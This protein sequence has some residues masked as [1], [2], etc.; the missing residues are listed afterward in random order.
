[1]APEK[2]GGIRGVWS[3]A[4]RRRYPLLLGLVFVLAVL[5][6][7][8]YARWTHIYSYDSYYYMNL[9]RGL[10][11]GFSYSLRGM[12]HGKF[13]PLYPLLTGMFSLPFRN[14]ELAGKAVN[15]AFSSLAVFPIYGMG[16][17]LLDGKAGLFAALFLACEPI[18]VTWSTIPMSEGLFVFLLCT[19]FYLFLR[20]WKARY[21]GGGLLLYGAAFVAGL[22]ALTRWEG[23]LAM[24]IFFALALYGAA[25]KRM[26]YRPVLFMALFFILAYSPWLLR[27]IAVR[28]NP[29]PL[30]YLTEISAHRETIAPL[31]LWGRFK[32]YLIFSESIALYGTTHT[33]NFGL[34]LLGYAGMALTLLRRNLR[35]YFLPLFLWWS[36]LG[37]LH[38]FFFY[39]SSRYIVGAAA[40]LCLYAG[41]AFSSL[42]AFLVPSFPRR[43]LRAITVALMVLLLCAVCAGSIPIIRD[44]FW[45]DILRMEDD[46]GG[47]ALRELMFWARDNLPQDAVLA[48]HAGQMPAFYLGREVLYIGTWSNF[49]PA[50][51]DQ[52]NPWPDV[53]EE[54]VDY[55]ILYASAPVLEEGLL[56]S[57]MPAELASYMEIEKVAVMEPVLDVDDV[58]YA[59]LVSLH[60]PAEP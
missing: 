6:R 27:N 34:L 51:V 12:P 36:L 18:S 32:K 57:G 28:G 50:D 39:F 14:Y 9:A 8:R 47:I 20:W 38:F 44:H 7:C 43:A 45:R 13:L 30:D 11:R 1:L 25:R 4:Y 37:P 41:I 33:Y 17:T 22:A 42:Y 52:E 58:N 5:L 19:S 60:P 53:R 46:C 16:K 3:Q 23:M 24:F 49:D 35:P 29:F 48:A 26:G 55:F 10:M 56:M 21:R 54:G 2:N 59:F 40:A 15:V 31:I